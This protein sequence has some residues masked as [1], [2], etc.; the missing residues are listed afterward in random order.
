MFKTNEGMIDRAVRVIAGI[1]L[2][3]AFFMYPD[4]SWRYWTLIGIVPLATGLLGICPVY[5]ILG[6]STCPMKK[7]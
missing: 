1:A 7:A 2:L 3:A 5:S 4:A 6:I